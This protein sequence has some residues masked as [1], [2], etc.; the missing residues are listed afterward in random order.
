M[1]GGS[2]CGGG[3]VVTEGV[4]ILRPRTALHPLKFIQFSF[5]IF[6]K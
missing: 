4:K 3:G 2:I 6:V 1:R 5:P